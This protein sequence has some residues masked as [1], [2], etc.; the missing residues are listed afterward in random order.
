MASLRSSTKGKWHDIYKGTTS[1]AHGPKGMN[2]LFVDGHS[3]IRKW[4]D[5]RTR[6]ILRFGVALPLGIAS[7][8]NLDVAWLQERSS[9]KET[10]PT[11]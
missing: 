5:G 10:N 3:E 2:L 9:V 7:P 1:S 6:P 8:N 11:R 4:V